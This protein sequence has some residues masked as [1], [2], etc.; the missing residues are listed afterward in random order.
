MIS[1]V[2][3]TDIVATDFN[4]L[5]KTERETHRTVCSAH[6]SPVYMP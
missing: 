2:A 4:P 6:I 3:T 1:G 5:V